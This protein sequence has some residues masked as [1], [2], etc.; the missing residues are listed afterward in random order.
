M[1]HTMDEQQKLRAELEAAKVVLAMTR[2][3]IEKE[4]GVLQKMKLENEVF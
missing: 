1:T 2:K 4:N 3:D